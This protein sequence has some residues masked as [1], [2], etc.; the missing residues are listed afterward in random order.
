[1]ALP[2]DRVDPS[3][4]RLHPDHPAFERIVA[5]HRAALAAE[6]PAY[7]DPLTGLSVMTAS[8]LWD[9]GHCCE[10]GCRHCPYLER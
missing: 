10:V 2:E 6:L 7:R 1:M 8:F 4:R 9:R 3:P 5:A